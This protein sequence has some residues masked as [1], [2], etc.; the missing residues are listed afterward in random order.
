MTGPIEILYVGG[1]GRS[2][3]TLLDRMVGRLPGFVSVGEARELWRRGVIENRLCGCGNPFSDCPFWTEVG[4]EAYGGWSREHAVEMESEGR[5]LDSLRHAG[6]LRERVGPSDAARAYLNRLAPLYRAVRDVG[7]AKVVVDSSKLPNYAGLLRA[8]PD[9][10]LRLAHL[11]RDSRGVANSW[12]KEIARVD[13]TADAGLMERYGA[14]AASARYLVYNALTERLARS[15]PHAT[16]VRYEDLVAHP[17]ETLAG[18]L[19]AVGEP[20]GP[21]AFGWLHG[22]VA[23]LGVSHTVDGNPMRM[24]QGPVPL[25]ADRTWREQLP[26]RERSV[27]TGLTLPL[28]WHYRYL[29]RSRAA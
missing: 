22:T 17:Q 28:L 24:Q 4:R 16:R 9:V 12:R 15:L 19:R 6:W 7:E 10:D 20:A 11:V 5:R 14:L 29:E 25:V 26:A 1:W 23:D 21:D 3:S 8:S 2:G 13:A 18:M 27:V